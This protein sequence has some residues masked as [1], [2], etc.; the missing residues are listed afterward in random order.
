MQFVTEHLGHYSLI[1][2]FM[3]EFSGD[4]GLSVLGENVL[5][6]LTDPLLEQR[7][8]DARVVK[9]GF[10]QQVDVQFYVRL[11]NPTYPLDL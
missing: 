3:F 8:D 9:I 6:E 10:I 5:R 4:A 1:G 11:V 2:C 7:G